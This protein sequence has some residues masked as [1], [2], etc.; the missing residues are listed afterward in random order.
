MIAPFFLFGERTKKLLPACTPFLLI[1][2]EAGSDNNPDTSGTGFT[3]VLKTLPSASCQYRS[4][5]PI[6]KLPLIAQANAMPAREDQLMT[7]LSARISTAA[8]FNASLTPRFG[9]GRAGANGE[10]RAARQIKRVAALN[11]D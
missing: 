3:P 8:F 5:T 7:R 6:S 2:S 10:L 1:T 9:A 4:F 11:E